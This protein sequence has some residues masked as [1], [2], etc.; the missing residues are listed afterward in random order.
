MILILLMLSKNGK[1][2]DRRCI[3]PIDPIFLWKPT[4]RAT[5]EEVKNK[6]VS[7]QCGNCSK[8]VK[9]EDGRRP[10]G[11]EERRSAAAAE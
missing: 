3:M 8:A 9:R 6:K 5:K 2:L 1:I 11:E 4:E 7:M 10:P